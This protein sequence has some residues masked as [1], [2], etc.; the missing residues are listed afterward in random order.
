MS[1]GGSH[2]RFDADWL[3]TR[4]G[5]DHRSR[6]ATLLPSLASEW[7][8]RGWTRV[9]DLGCGTGSNLRYLASR[10]PGEQ[11]WILLDHDRGLL[12]RVETPP[13]V[14]AIIRRQGDLAEDGLAA[15][16]ETDLVTA[17]ALLDLVSE[18]WLRRLVDACRAGQRGAHFALS[19][20]GA[21]H[22]SADDDEDAL[23]RDAVNAHQ[24]RDKGLGPA[25]GPDAVEVA[26][27]LFRSAGYR[28]TLGGSPWR[29]GPGERA[30]ARRLVDGWEAA[31]VVQRP[32]REQVI[33]SWAERRRLTVATGVFG[34]TVG[35]RD[36]C[37]LPPDPP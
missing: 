20:D 22:W 3:E 37:A 19:Y 28:V 15:V 17:S 26:A 16:G 9:L 13:G 21:I 10:L 24:R 1:D 32:D 12:A 6:D 36:L 2:A 18:R 5:V 27:G 8:R 30:L 35:H 25:L 29:L 14:G 33:R 11:E 31:A 7:R 4:E 23:V 34:L